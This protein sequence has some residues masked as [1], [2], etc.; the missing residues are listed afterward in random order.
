MNPKSQMDPEKAAGSRRVFSYLGSQEKYPATFGPSSVPIQTQSH[1]NADCIIDSQ[2]MPIYGRG[3]TGFGRGDAKE[4][5]EK[6]TFLLFQGNALHRKGILLS[7]CKR[8]GRGPKRGSRFRG[9]SSFSVCEF[10]RF[11]LLFSL[12]PAKIK[13]R[14][15][16]KNACNTRFYSFNIKK[17]KWLI[18]FCA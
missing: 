6:R 8:T 16:Q 12:N 13:H 3:K 10:S 5:R 17:I 4:E 15:C 18:F 2:G 9:P 11:F 1:T 14:K 7:Q